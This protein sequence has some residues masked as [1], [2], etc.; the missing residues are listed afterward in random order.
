MSKRFWMAATLVAGAAAGPASGDTAEVQV[1]KAVRQDVSPPLRSLIETARLGPVVTGPERQVPNRFDVERVAR[2]ESPELDRDPL[3]DASNAVVSTSALTPAPSLS[4]EGT[5][6]DDNAA[7]VGFRIVPPDTNG[8]VGLDHYVQ[9]NNLVLEIFDKATGATVLGP[10]AGNTLWAGFGGICQTNNDGDPIVLY[11]HLA[12]RWVFSQFANAAAGNNGHQCFAVSTT[13]DPTGPYFRYDFLVSPGKFNDYPKIG[14]WPDAY[15]MSINEFNAGPGVFSGAVTVAVERAKMLAG[16]AARMVRIPVA[17]LFN[18]GLQPSNLEGPAPGAG[19]PN[20]YVAQ[21]DGFPDGYRLWDFH[22][23]WTNPGL[24]TLTL[25]PL[26]ATAAFDSS[27]NQVPQ[28]APGE[29]LD[30]LAGSFTMYRAQFR[31]FGGYRSIVLNHTVDVGGNRAG[32]RWAELRNA[33]GGWALHQTGTQGPADNLH[34]WMGSI[35]QDRNNNI[36]LGYSVSGVTQA[37]DI[38]YVSRA[39]TDPLGTLPGGE[40][41]LQAG[42]GVQ[43][44]SFSRW[45]DYSAMSS[46]PFPDCTFW[47]TQEYYENTASFD[48]KTRVGSFT[49]PKC[50]PSLLLR[51]NGDAGEVVR[52]P[53]GPFQVTLAGEDGDS[54]APMDWYY[55]VI[56]GGSVYWLTPGGFSLG[57]APL[58]TG[59]PPADFPDTVIWNAPLPAGTTATFVLFLVEGGAVRAVDYITGVVS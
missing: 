16:G 53:A 40:I 56:V 23:D 47:Y 20:T 8:D 26:V 10:A 7:V 15:Y 22:V 25:L 33:G 5:T 32:V 49:F 2:P 14:V 39:A 18:F 6:D 50:G 57:A 11:D 34:R 54:V 28:A 19:T 52:V 9:M 48:F 46:D 31:Q 3:L 4:F 17:G 58:V 30:A 59:V 35:A 44:S 42:T 45:G 51:L 12:D 29:L 21:V 41:T 24:S 55:A 1:V 13:P 37:A 43:V 38:R 36:A 27:V